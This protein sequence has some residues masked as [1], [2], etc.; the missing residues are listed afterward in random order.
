MNPGLAGHRGP[1]VRGVTGPVQPVQPVQPVGWV[2]GEGGAV[3]RGTRSGRPLSGPLCSAAFWPSSCPLLPPG[4]RTGRGT[5]RAAWGQGSARAQTSLGQGCRDRLG[6][7][8]TG[9]L[10][11][12]LFCP[13]LSG[14]SLSLTEGGGREGRRVCWAFRALPALPAGPAAHRLCRAVAAHGAPRGPAG[15]RW[16]GA[17]GGR[18]A[19]L[20]IVMY[21]PLGQGAP[22]PNLPY[23]PREPCP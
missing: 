9:R 3:P 2:A 21:R 6:L 13:V 15:C 16:P 23:G 8:V 4:H 1:S 19:P 7:G 20:C 11:G 18:Q 17:R 10:S 22:S 14:V 5:E 12:T